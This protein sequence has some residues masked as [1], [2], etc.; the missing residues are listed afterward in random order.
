MFSIIFVL[1]I[2][3]GLMWVIYPELYA[4]IRSDK[5]AGRMVKL[6][7]AVRDIKRTLR[8]ILDIENNITF[9]VKSSSYY[10][11]LKAC[12]K[13][14]YNENITTNIRKII[15]TIDN[16]VEY[17]GDLYRMDNFLKLSNVDNWDR[18]ISYF[19]DDMIDA[20]NV[21]TEV[22]NSLDVMYRERNNMYRAT[23]K[24]VK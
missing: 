15:T 24:K 4:Y 22:L 6:K 18:P 16:L 7:E 21:C 10:H 20:V 2:V 3:P 12:K 19:E 23:D 9:I 13:G 8:D 14:D 11:L 17:S 1:V 5:K